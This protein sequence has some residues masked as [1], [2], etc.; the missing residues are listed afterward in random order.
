[1]SHITMHSN[2]AYA[3]ASISSSFPVPIGDNSCNYGELDHNITINQQYDSPCNM[4]G[5]HFG[6]QIGI[7]SCN[8]CRACTTFWTTFAVGDG[9]N[10][11]HHNTCQSPITPNPT[12]EPA[13]SPTSGPTLSPTTSPTTPLPTTSPSMSMSP[14]QDTFSTNSELR[15]AIQEYL[16]QG[17]SSDLNCQARSDYGGVVSP[18]WCCA[19]VFRIRYLQH[20]ILQFRLGTGTCPKWR[21]SVTCSLMIHTSPLLELIHSTNRSIGIQVSGAGKINKQMLP[22][23]RPTH[24]IWTLLRIC[25]KDG[26][27]VLYSEG[28]Q[29]TTIN[30]RYFQGYECEY[31]ICVWTN[32][33]QI[34]ICNS[35][36]IYLDGGHVLWC[37]CLQSSTAVWYFQ[38]Y[39]CESIPFVFSPTWFSWFWCWIPTHHFTRCLQCSSGL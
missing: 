7:G 14:T 5:V 1:M 6:G 37:T 12:P 16:G 32:G 29:S 31:L 21:I 15:T 3:C 22:P 35:Y 23:S 27:H 34:L 8:G 4:L 24:W 20:L 18:L 25:Y 36:S 39:G 10:N 19:F 13:T 2:G 26:V 11:D 30:I 9:E 33:N 28:L 17:C 38:G